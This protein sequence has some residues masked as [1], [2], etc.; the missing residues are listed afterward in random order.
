MNLRTEVMKISKINEHLYLGSVAHPRE[1]TEQFKKLNIDVVINCC[2]D[3]THVNK[4]F[5]FENYL[6]D[7]GVGASITRYLDPI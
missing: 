5:S 4:K 6:I 2:N 1:E 7:D 3:Y